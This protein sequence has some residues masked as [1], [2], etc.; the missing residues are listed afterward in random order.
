[1]G[2]EVQRHS[3]QNGTKWQT[4]LATDSEEKAIASYGRLDL[5][6]CSDIGERRKGQPERL[7]AYEPVFYVGAKPDLSAGFYGL[8]VTPCFYTKDAL[9]RYCNKNKARVPTDAG[10]FPDGFINEWPKAVEGV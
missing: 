7:G 6:V 3:F 1:M 5:T 2:Y 9:E 4:K 10:S 8:A